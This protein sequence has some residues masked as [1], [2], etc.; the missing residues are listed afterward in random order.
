MGFSQRAPWLYGRGNSQTDSTTGSSEVQAEVQRQLGAM[1]RTQ[2]Q[3]L[4]EMRKEL[5]YLRAERMR[6][7]EAGRGDERPQQ[8]G[9]P[10]GLQYEGAER[11]HPEGPPRGLRYEGNEQPQPEGPF[12]G[13][14]SEGNERPQLQGD[15][16]GPQNAAG[17]SWFG[18]ERRDPS[19]GLASMAVEQEQQDRN[20]RPR[21][22]LGG[23]E[24]SVLRGPAGQPVVYSGVWSKYERYPV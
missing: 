5:Y 10:R 4:E 20:V 12:R 15:P 1:M 13:L 19:P 8:Q 7:L 22:S 3:Q 18:S 24:D 6:L 9:D 16:R 2:S 23:E 21:V 14:Q 11:P 17:L